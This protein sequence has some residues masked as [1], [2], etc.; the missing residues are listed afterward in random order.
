MYVALTL[1][2]FCVNIFLL[3]CTLT[4]LEIKCW[5]KKGF[6][7]LIFYC[8]IFFQ[9]LP[10]SS[11]NQP[12]DVSSIRSMLDQLVVIKLNGGLGTSMGCRSDFLNLIL[13]LRLVPLKDKLLPPPKKKNNK[14]FFTF[15]CFQWPKICY[16][17]EIWTNIPGL[18]SSTNRISQQ[19]IWRK[20]SVG[21][22]EQLQHRR[23]HDEDHQEVRRI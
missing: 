9:I 15:S 3:L 13:I 1:T 5:F 20:C 11:L 23:G 17:C 14:F 2:Y 12:E 19:E 22:D 7:I 6:L 16:P 18:N 21:P 10:Y 8:D 4:L